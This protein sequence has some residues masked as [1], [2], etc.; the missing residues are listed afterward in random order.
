LV[1]DSNDIPHI[2]YLSEYFSLCYTYYHTGP[3]YFSLIDPPDGAEVGP[4]VTLDWENSS[5][6]EGNVTYD[7]WY[8]TSTDFEPR[9]EIT[10]LTTSTYTFPVGI[11][12]IGVTYY[13]KVRAWDG[14]EERWCNQDYWSFTVVDDT[15]I[16]ISSFS[17]RSVR[18]GIEVTW[19]CSEPGVGF[20]LYRS[21]EATGARTKL[22]EMINAELITGESPYLY[23]DVGVSDGVTYNYWLEVIDAGGASETFGPVS[24]TAGM[25][26]PNSYALYQS[27]PNPAR[28]TA[29][30]AFDLP[31]ETYVSLVVYD[32]SG[33]KVVTLVDESLPAGTYERSL[34]GLAP[35]VYVYHLA[36]S[37]FN[38]AKKMVILE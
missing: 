2:A 30:I 38:A 1:M 14:F 18:N 34:S 6:D 22:R 13:W 31:E 26:V 20:N 12:E 21:A 19:E 7:I 29:S 33:R 5:S 24:C 37:A 17:A 32:L 11:L 27:R 16:A 10:D 25:Y 8:S 4:T 15:D 9:E 35:G 23:L 36:T 28:R 3:S